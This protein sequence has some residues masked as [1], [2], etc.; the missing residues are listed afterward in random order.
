VLGVQ[1]HGGIEE[2]H[3]LR[4]AFLQEHIEEVG[5]VIQVR[6]GGHRRFAGADALP[7]GHDGGQLGDQAH[8]HAQGR[9][10]GCIVDIVI[11]VGQHGGGGLQHIHG[12]GLRGSG[13]ER[14]DNSGGISVSAARRCLMAFNSFWP[15]RFFEQQQMDDLF[16]AGL[17]GQIGTR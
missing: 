11:M 2:M 16:E 14:F 10:M 3:Q 6:I 4:W 5:A 9:V 7:G 15:G 13:S 8:G 17:A 12:Q 1:H